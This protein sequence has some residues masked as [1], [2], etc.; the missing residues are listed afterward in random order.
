MNLKKFIESSTKKLIDNNIDSASTDVKF[1]ITDYYNYE[2]HELI[3]NEAKVIDENE[4]MELTSKID[5]RVLGEPVAYILGYKHFYKSKFIVNENVLI[6]RPETELLVEEALKWCT[7]KT[8]LE[9]LDLGS[10]SGCLG[11]SVLKEL[12]GAKLT[13]IDISADAIDI[14]KKNADP[15]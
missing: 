11:Q 5:R 14:A 4:L 7:N 6:P 13:A 12:T 9:I 8:N 15:F 2:L 10:G 3:L 1:L